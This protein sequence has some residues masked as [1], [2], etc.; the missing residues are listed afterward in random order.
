MTMAELMFSHSRLLSLQCEEM[1]LAHCNF[2]L[3]EGDCDL[4]EDLVRTWA[5]EHAVAFFRTDFDT[6]TYANESGQS[7]E[8]AARELRYRWFSKI[9]IENGFD[10]VATAHHADDNAETLLLNLTR[11]TG[12]KG[13]CGM[14]SE[15][16]LPYSEGK[17]RLVR[18]L[19]GF[20]RE[21]IEKYAKEHNVPFRTD[22]SNL[23][24]KYRRNRVRNEILPQMKVLNPSVVETLNADMEHFR[25]A[26][27]ILD[28]W[29]AEHASIIQND[30][31]RYEDL[32]K[33]EGWE[34]LIWRWLE[35][36]GFNSA[37]VG[38][39]C[40]LIKEGNTVSGHRFHTGEWTLMTS[41]S[42]M[43]LSRTSACIPIIDIESRTYPY[44]SGIEFDNG[45]L[46][47]DAEK[48][49]AWEV[50]CW[51]NGDWFIPF[52]MKGRKKLSDWFKDKKADF[53]EKAKAA[54]IAPVDW[55][56]GHIAAVFTEEACRQDES[57]RVTDSTSEVLEL[58][59]ASDRK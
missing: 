54:V 22:L 23:E 4:D 26:S 15:D 35:P 20:T 17:V 27:A 24:S 57:T 36:K 2:H 32:L 5:E 8:M 11:G 48:T 21:W 14:T 18:P 3:R 55:E 49:G 39:I 28:L 9:A 38:D 29:Y 12:L 1:A 42:G 10:A 56:D 16:I 34:Y 43:S 40:R 7:I 58:K 6:E 51:R 44:T 41:F 59:V 47:L 31:V 37:A 19:L 25:Q 33:T 50:R 46:L 53:G 13:I 30:S 45:R 52:G